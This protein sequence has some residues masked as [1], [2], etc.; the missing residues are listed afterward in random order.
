MSDGQFPDTLVLAFPYLYSDNGCPGGFAAQLQQGNTFSVAF[1]MTQAP[2][3][4]GENGLVTLQAS[5]QS[6]F[7]PSG[8]MQL[9]NEGL[10]DVISFMSGGGGDAGQAQIFGGDC[11][12]TKAWLQGQPEG[13][14]FTWKAA[15]GLGDGCI[16]TNVQM[17]GAEA[18]LLR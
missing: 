8:S 10:A 1:D 9:D 3:A 15:S 2:H 11:T 6:N 12:V 14:V 16:A 17:G 18:A 13:D 7:Q 5:A 4:P